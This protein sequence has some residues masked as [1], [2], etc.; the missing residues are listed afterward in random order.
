MIWSGL[1]LDPATALE[2]YDVDVVLPSTSIA[3]YYADLP[4]SQPLG[5]LLAIAHDADDVKAVDATSST[6]I[7][8]EVLQPVIDTCRVVKDAYEVA[9]IRQANAI[10]TA[11]HV[12][13]L[14][15]LKTAT[16][17]RELAAVFIERC[18][19]LGSKHQ[20][21]HGIFGA[22]HN[23]ATLHYV[24]NDRPLAGKWNLL[25]DAA[26]EWGCYCADVTRTM[27]LP[28]IG[29]NRTHFN[30]PSRAVYS[31]VQRMQESCLGM[32]RAGVQWENVQLRA[33]E[34]AIDALLALGIL[35]LGDDGATPKDILAAGTSIAFFPHGL[36]HFLG[37][38]T[39]DT[40]GRPD[41]KDDALMMRFLRVRGRLPA[42]SVVTVEPG[43]YFCRFIIE[44]Y[45]KDERHRA[46][47]D[48]KVLDGYWD[49]GGVRIEGEVFFFVCVVF[50]WV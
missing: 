50:A 45:L 4:K 31:A 12:A 28:S 44:P 13:V 23:A 24:H 14:R 32:I 38:D 17:E 19:A 30:A 27:P 46:F 21:Y 34:T 15:R 5:Q 22:G 47:I 49:V 43:I 2:I 48:E 25:V 37:L 3:D 40:G 20:A 35:R 42:G 16:N 36:G 10:S 8:L 1:P 7:E 11:A 33:H 39:H 18:I 9:S 41:Y 26:A 6:P 29:A